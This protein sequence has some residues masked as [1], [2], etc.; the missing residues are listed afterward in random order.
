M[1]EL[2]EKI[3]ILADTMEELIAVTKEI[4]ITQIKIIK[5]LQSNGLISND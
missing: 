5:L 4:S 1:E 3:E 2:N